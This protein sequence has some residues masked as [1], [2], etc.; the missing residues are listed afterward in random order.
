[1]GLYDEEV[2]NWTALYRRNTL[3]SKQVLMAYVQ[4]GG[5]DAQLV[6]LKAGDCADFRLVLEITKGAREMGI[7]L[8]WPNGL[9]LGQ[10]KKDGLD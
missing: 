7:P 9:E 1:L 5:F 8:L 2:H 10:M 4:A 3:L 6:N